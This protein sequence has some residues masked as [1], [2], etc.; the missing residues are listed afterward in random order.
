MTLRTISCLCLVA[1]LW[2]QLAKAVFSAD[3][4]PQ[5][6]ETGMVP[7]DV[8]MGNLSGFPGHAGIYLG[9]WNKLPQRLQDAYKGIFNDE[10]LAGTMSGN[11]E[12]MDSYLIVDSY[13]PRVAI[14]P[15][16]EQFTG[17]TLLL[18]QEASEKQAGI[19]WRE[20]RDLIGD[21]ASELE[22]LQRAQMS[23]AWLRGDV[24]LFQTLVEQRLRTIPPSKK[25]L[26][27]YRQLID[28]LVRYNN[29]VDSAWKYWKKDE[30]QTAIEAEIRSFG[31]SKE[32]VAKALKKPRVPLLPQMA[33]V[34][35]SS[36]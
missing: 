2:C 29:D 33:I 10:D 17:Y 11:A 9:K 34:P 26:V 18:G 16:C 28:M 8:V 14:R 12:L 20:A 13:A 23:G 24:D 25:E 5:A 30:V 1:V 22:A 4:V 35:S 27:Y 15:L 36:P 19:L 7:G 31:G 3:P 32:S 21:N 6:D